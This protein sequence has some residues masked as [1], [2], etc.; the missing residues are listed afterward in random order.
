MTASEMHKAFAK[1]GLNK[2]DP[3]GEKFDHNTQQAMMESDST[4]YAPGTVCRVLQAGY[5]LHDRLLRPA[6]VDVVR[7]GGSADA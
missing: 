5:V 3:L 6:L 1:H 2:I 7:S 4:E